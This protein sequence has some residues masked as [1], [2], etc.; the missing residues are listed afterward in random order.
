MRGWKLMR[1]ILRESGAVTVYYA[2]LGL[3][4][5]AAILIWL[6]EPT[7]SSLWSSIWYCFTVVTTI[8]FGDNCATAVIPRIVTMILSFYSVF[9]MS[10]L[11]A[12]ITQYFI[13]GMKIKA[14][15][16]ASAFLDKLERLPELTKEDLKQLSQ[17]AKDFVR[18]RKSRK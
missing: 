17:Q 8:G 2:F 6:T 7:I 3:F 5:G 16:S 15:N 13:E 9:I 14:E 11:T 10:I 1:Q 12:L 18:H 4:F